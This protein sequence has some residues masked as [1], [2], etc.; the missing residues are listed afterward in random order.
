MLGNNQASPIQILLTLVACLGVGVNL[1]HT[2][3]GK[4]TSFA[5]TLSELLLPPKLS[6]KS[7]PKDF[8]QRYHV[9][10]DTEFCSAVFF[11]RLHI[12]IAFLMYF[13]CT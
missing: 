7:S 11:F 10:L 8:Q 2:V 5:K 12:C 3:S 9:V 4:S 13:Y 6:Y 1:I